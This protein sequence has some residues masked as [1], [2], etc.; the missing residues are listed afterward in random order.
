MEE[1][2]YDSNGK[3]IKATES[4]L[5]KRWTEKLYW[6]FTHKITK[7]TVF[8][9]FENIIKDQVKITG[10]FN[11]SR[12]NIGK[13]I[14]AVHDIADCHFMSLLIGPYP[15]YQTET[16]RTFCRRVST[17]IYETG[18][19]EEIIS[20]LFTILLKEMKH[21]FSDSKSDYVYVG[22]EGKR[23]EGTIKVK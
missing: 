15:K 5:I 19:K 10:S 4:E 13:K 23:E 2:C 8:D 3:P 22:V 14:I 16:L 21:R 6:L 17:L 7:E 11:C 9:A 12:E 1:T 20:I 18:A